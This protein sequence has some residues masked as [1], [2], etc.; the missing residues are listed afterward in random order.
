MQTSLVIPTDA[1]QV[2]RYWRL[3]Q[4]VK[5]F[6]P[7]A[8][9]H[10]EVAELIRSRYAELPA[11]Q[12]AVAEGLESSV[13]VSAKSEE[14]WLGLSARLRIYA[15]LGK[16][17]AMDIFTVTLKAAETAVGAELF[18]KLVSHDRTGSR[19]LVAVA[20]VKKAA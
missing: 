6:A 5:A 14:R 9:E 7:T 2:D 17:K 13:L 16:R 15:L 18:E 20:K 10:K 11:D 4:L 8:K 12:D 19:K 1:Q 3:D